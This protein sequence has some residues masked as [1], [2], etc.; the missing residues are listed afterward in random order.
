MLLAGLLM[1]GALR[2]PSFIQIAPARA[3]TGRAAKLLT[4]PA[5]AARVRLGALM[6]FLPCGLVYVALMKAMAPG[7]ML[8]GAASMAAFG[9]GTAGPLILLGAFS[10]YLARPLARYGATLTAASVTVM[11]LF[12]LVRGLMPVT[13]AGH[14]HPH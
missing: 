9:V 1:I 4:N 12:L 2:R 13:M 14:M 6:G 8:A 7:E 3:I 11:G 5:V 10:S